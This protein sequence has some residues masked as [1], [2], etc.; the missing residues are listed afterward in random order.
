[1]NKKQLID[2]LFA[3][4]ENQNIRYPKWELLSIIDPAFEVIIEALA[5]DEEVHLNK[6]GRFS[7]KHK[8]GARF[9]NINTG[10]K[11]TAP[12]KKLVQFT[13]HKGFRFTATPGDPHTAAPNNPATPENPGT[14]EDPGNP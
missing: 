1:M 3:K 10:Q 9:Y 2:A 4:L 5:R 14:D 8:K 11:E 6:F 13:P 12:D 7:I